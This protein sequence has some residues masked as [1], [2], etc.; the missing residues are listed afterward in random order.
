MMMVAQVSVGPSLV[1]M[2]MDMPHLFPGGDFIS[3]I[4]IMA[5]LLVPLI[6]MYVQLAGALPH[7]GGDYI[8]TTRILGIPWLG[9]ANNFFFVVG[10]WVSAAL[11]VSWIGSW[12]LATIFSYLGVLVNPGWAAWASFCASPNGT[13]LVGTLGIIWWFIIISLGTRFAFKVNFA[14]SDRW[15]NRVIGFRGST[16]NHH[17]AIFRTAV[18]QL[19]KTVRNDTSNIH[20][21]YSERPRLGFHLSNHGLSG[22]NFRRTDLRHLGILGERRWNVVGW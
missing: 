18:R 8:Y 9:F 15:H 1:L 19:L 4:I 21:D 14:V 7:T 10:E 2:V 12:A 6:V 3:T 13:F 16:G 22:R 20:I 17:A 5:V 11:F